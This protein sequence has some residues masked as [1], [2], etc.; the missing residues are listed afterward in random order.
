MFW[1]SS[2]IHQVQI[3]NRLKH[4]P[5]SDKPNGI[6]ITS[7]TCERVFSKMTIMK[8]KLRST[9]KQERLDS[10]LLLFTE[11]ELTSGIN[12]DSVIDEFNTLENRRMIL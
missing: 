5:K 10:L 12:L 11:Q 1:L 9:M 7:C 2:Q 6:S 8:S 4:L 3:F